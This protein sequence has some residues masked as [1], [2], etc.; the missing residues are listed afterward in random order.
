MKNL[1]NFEHICSLF[2]YWFSSSW[3]KLFNTYY[4]KNE[5][6]VQILFRNFYFT[7]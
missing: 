1:Q 4:H 2:P 3:S 7:F 5:R 6:P